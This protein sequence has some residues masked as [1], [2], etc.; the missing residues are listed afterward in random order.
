MK[1][2]KK[3]V[4]QGVG[5]KGHYH[6][7][8]HDAVTGELKRTYD[9][10]NLIPSVGLEAFAAQMSGDNST[11]IGDNLFIAVGDDATAPASGDTILGNE[12]ARKGVGS[13]A[14]AGAVAN[15]VVFFAAT[16]ATGTHR[17]FGMFGDGNADVASATPD[18]GVL[19]SHVA[20]NVAVSAVETL[21]IAFQL[22]FS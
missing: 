14:F 9:Y 3:N 18:S 6:V 12:T 20:A 19:F 22:T 7:E 8:I 5:L 4:K 10:D 17:E 13:T 21:T 16:E 2:I 1:S 15:N 11:D